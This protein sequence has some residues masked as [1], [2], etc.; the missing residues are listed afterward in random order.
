MKLATILFFA[1]AAFHSVAMVTSQCSAEQNL[2]V[3][4][5]DGL[6][7]TTATAC[8]ICG[9]GVIAVGTDQPNCEQAGDLV[10]GAAPACANQC[11]SCAD[12]GFAYWDC[13]F[14]DECGGSL[15]CN[16]SYAFK[17]SYA[18]SLVLVAVATT[19]WVA[20]QLWM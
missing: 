14:N 12:E 13:L 11:G 9:Q 5:L 19:Y 20:A 2:I 3:N 6:D 16:P 1:I 7:T 10:C 4:C 15:P 18:W 17:V 8:E